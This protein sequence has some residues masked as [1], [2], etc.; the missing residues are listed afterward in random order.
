M[1][2][3]VGQRIPRVSLKATCPDRSSIA[4][5]VTWRRSVGSRQSFPLGA[6]SSLGLSADCTQGAHE[7]VDWHTQKAV[8]AERVAAGSRLAAGK[9]VAVAAV[10]PFQRAPVDAESVD[11]RPGWALLAGAM[12]LVGWGMLS[13]ERYPIVLYGP[14]QLPSIL[15]HNVAR[16][17]WL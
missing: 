17:A 12:P 10:A 7:M 14:L 15:P 6:S 8:L 3:Y 13:A 2:A 4:T 16:Y 9:R 5:T 11:P 1:G